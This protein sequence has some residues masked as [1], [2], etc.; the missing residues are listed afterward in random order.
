MEMNTAGAA[1]RSVKFQ[2]VLGKKSLES[3]LFDENY[4]RFVNSKANPETLARSGRA[5]PLKSNSP[6]TKNNSAVEE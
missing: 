3:V 6:Q 5:L 1:P 2:P 4:H